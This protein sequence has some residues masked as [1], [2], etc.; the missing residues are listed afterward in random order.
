[1]GTGPYKTESDAR[2]AAKHSKIRNDYGPLKHGHVIGT[3]EG[4]EGRLGR[5]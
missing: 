1:M 3:L 4:L 2:E 5:G